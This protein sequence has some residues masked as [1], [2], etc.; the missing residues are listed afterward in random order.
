LAT[1]ADHQVV[2]RPILLHHPP[3]SFVRHHYAA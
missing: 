1:L 2:V 3:N